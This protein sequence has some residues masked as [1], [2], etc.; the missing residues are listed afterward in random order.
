[1]P[2]VLD[3]PPP[4]FLATLTRLV[5]RWRVLQDSTQLR[6]G[7]MS[8]L[9]GFAI[10]TFA[11]LRESGAP[12]FQDTEAFLGHSVY[13]REHGG[14]WGFLKACFDGS[15]PIAERHPLFML[16]LQGF[17]ERDAAFFWNARLL[18]LGLGSVL[19][20]TFVWMMQRRHGTGPALIGGLLFAISGALVIGS[21]RVTQEPL[22]GLCTLWFWWFI[23]GG[24]RGT[25]TTEPGAVPEESPRTGQWLA[26]GVCLGLA[27]LAKSPAILILAAVLVSSV[28][29]RGAE[30]IRRGRL[31]VLL[32]A[33]LAIAS[34]LL[35]RNVV[36]HG[37]PL[38]GGVNSNITW[39]DRWGQLGEE[40]SILRYDQYGIMRIDRNGLPTLGDYLETHDL[41]DMASRLYRGMKSE[42][43]RVMP[44][45]VGPRSLERTPR[46]AIG[47]L[48]FAIAL[49][50]WWQRRRSWDAMLLFFWSAAFIT[51]FAWDT[52]F[53]EPRYLAPLV[54]IWIGYASVVLWQAWQRLC[55]RQALVA[56]TAL[57]VGTSV[58]GSA[59]PLVSGRVTQ[60]VEVIDASPAYLRLVDW[61]KA[62]LEPG[63]T[64]LL[65]PTM[66]FYGLLWLVDT[67]VWV[68]RTPSVTSLEAWNRYLRDRNVRYVV[69]GEES[70]RGE[71][72][73]LVDVFALYFRTEADGTVRQLQPLPGWRTAAIDPGT[74][75]RYVVLEAL[76]A[77]EPAA[78]P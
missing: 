73:S 68:I 46:R 58:V 40:H 4:S 67:E 32:V 71:S 7:T 2:T 57:V 33:T 76:P 34:P 63:D 11:A 22:F 54:P 14:W 30:P 45:A 56:A 55:G 66:E 10:W 64:I 42:L 60:P 35:V 47:L 13:I 20:L 51:F 52:M 43:L 31:L 37:T 62:E 53:P 3:P 29:F 44:D 65:G 69:I 78:A 49:I 9:V 12:S 39:V 48:V 41:R 75:S 21:S 27:W 16:L 5:E 18:N 77:V 8:L 28:L 25:D 61:F 70:M 36:G 50:G 24:S 23:T 17:A 59:A 1:L 6:I 38:Y 72:R 26:A 74:P 19:L 15:F